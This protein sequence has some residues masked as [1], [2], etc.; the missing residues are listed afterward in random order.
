MKDQ[1]GRLEEE[2][3]G[4]GDTFRICR[5][6]PKYM[7]NAARTFGIDAYVGSLEDGKLADI[8][9]CWPGVFGIKPELV[10]KGGFIVRSAMGDSAA[11]LMTCEPV[12]VR[13]QWGAFG[14]AGKAL[15]ACFVN[16]RAV[17]D[18]LAGKLG[19]LKAVLA[20]RGARKLNKSRMLQTMPAPMWRS[21][22]M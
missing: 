4:R 9:L 2:T 22:P 13:P 17:D 19:L 21:I 15:S 20:A 11:S 8:V 5:Y 14:E 16:Q 1:R 12:L 18:D 6:L 10:I 7:I 3:T